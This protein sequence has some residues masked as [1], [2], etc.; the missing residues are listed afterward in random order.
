MCLRDFLAALHSKG[1]VVSEAQLRW[2]IASGKIARPKLDGSLRFDFTQE[3]LEQLGRLFK[4]KAKE[5][6]P[7]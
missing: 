6:A 7:C 2:A 1:V 4:V 3:H 5:A